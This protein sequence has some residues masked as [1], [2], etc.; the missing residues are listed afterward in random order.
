M[1]GSLLRL[2]WLLGLTGRLFVHPRPV[3]LESS[4]LEGS[5]ADVADDLVF[6]WAGC[7]M[8]EPLHLL[9]WAAQGYL[10]G[11]ENPEVALD[12]ALLIPCTIAAVECERERVS[13]A[14]CFPFLQSER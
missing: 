8:R 4:R 1:V 6:G 14:P 7:P 11:L 2:R 13:C 5:T 9:S 3:R 12:E 10:V